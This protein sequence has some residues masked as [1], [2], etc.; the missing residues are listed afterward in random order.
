[1]S[2]ARWLCL[3]G[4]QHGWVVTG[5]DTGNESMAAYELFCPTCGRLV[6]RDRPDESWSWV[7]MD[8]DAQP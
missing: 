8:G 7:P 6:G 4:L 2:D 5:W 3:G 1:M